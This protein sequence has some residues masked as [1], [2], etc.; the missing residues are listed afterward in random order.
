MNKKELDWFIHEPA[1]NDPEN[2]KL[3]I[4]IHFIDKA[5]KRTPLSCN[6]ILFPLQVKEVEQEESVMI[7]LLLESFI[8]SGFQRCE[9]LHRLVRDPK[10]VEKLKE[11]GNNT[12]YKFLELVLSPT[13]DGIEIQEIRC[14]NQ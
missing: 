9:F 2:S 7:P 13:L 5:G 1:T 4:L 8:V 14:N 12:C 6:R 10:R 3:E 11:M